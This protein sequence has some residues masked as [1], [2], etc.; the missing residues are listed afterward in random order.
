SGY[1]SGLASLTAYFTSYIFTKNILAGGPSSIYPAGNYFP[2]TLDNVGFVDRAGGNYRLTA[3][4]PYKN[5]GTDSRDIGA[6]LDAIQSAIAGSTLS[7]NQPLLVTITASTTTGVA[8][9]LVSFSSSVSSP[10]LPITSYNWDFGDGQTSSLQLPTHT[11]MT[12]GVFTASLLVTD[13][14][15]ATG[16]AFVTLNIT[17]PTSPPPIADS[18]VI[19]Y[20]ADA[21]VRVGNFSVVSD[22]SA[23]GGARIGNPDAGAPKLV[24]ALASP[25]TYFELTFSA[26]AGTAYRLWVRGKADNDSPYNDSFFVQFSDSV[27]SSNT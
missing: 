26:Q 4:S 13:S 15:G 19:L 2:A 3:S 10:N 8:P 16:A 11:Y 17:N 7:P 25:S 18:D 23:A 27:D 14:S 21:T 1:G 6:D 24:D 20:A 22:S 12:A 5:A 9:L